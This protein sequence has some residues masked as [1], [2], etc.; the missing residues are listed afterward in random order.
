MCPMIVTA[1]DLN[2][3][4]PRDSSTARHAIPHGQWLQWKPP[5]EA[6]P[7]QYSLGLPG[8]GGRPHPAE[9]GAHVHFTLRL[10]YSTARTVTETFLVTLSVA[11]DT[12]CQTLPIP[13]FFF[14][15]TSSRWRFFTSSHCCCSVLA[16]I[17]KY[18]YVILIMR[19]FLSFY[20]QH[21]WRPQLV[22]Y[23]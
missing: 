6:S 5:R 17:I 21:Y 2:P 23:A 15:Q 9:V 7:P 11:V 19:P 18:K 1:V 22:L 4:W 14:R 13:T 8:E 10:S 20:R 3:A 12:I 16:T